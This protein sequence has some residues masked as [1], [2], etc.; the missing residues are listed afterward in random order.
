MKVVET[1][2]P[3]ISIYDRILWLCK[4]PHYACP[5][6]NISDRTHENVAAR[7][8]FLQLIHTVFL[9]NPQSVA[10]LIRLRRI[11]LVGLPYEVIV[12]C[13]NR[14]WKQR[15]FRSEISGIS[16]HTYTVQPF[17]HQPMLVMARL[18]GITQWFS[19]ISHTSLSTYYTSPLSRLFKTFLS[20]KLRQCTLLSRTFSKKTYRI[21]LITMFYQLF[22]WVDKIV[23]IISTEHVFAGVV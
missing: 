4:L 22:C 7:L 20:F 17:L 6:R 21:P 11:R 13:S 16:H 18:L 15:L 9:P 23:S 1:E 3:I 19:S 14:S 2:D 10:H 8:A 12:Q 5:S